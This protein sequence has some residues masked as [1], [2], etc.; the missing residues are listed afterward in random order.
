[1]RERKAPA[2][3]RSEGIVCLLGGDSDASTTYSVRAQFLARFGVST[4]RLGLI[5]SLHFGEVRHG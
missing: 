3:P 2:P 1:M 4:K 5:A